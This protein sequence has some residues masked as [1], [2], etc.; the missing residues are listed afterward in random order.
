MFWSSLLAEPRVIQEVRQG[1]CRKIQSKDK[2]K[3]RVS[4]DKRQKSVMA[5][6]V[7]RGVKNRHRS[8]GLGVVQN[9]KS[10]FSG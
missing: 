4:R 6:S 7:S 8:G 5:A 9:P 1:V 2:I 3:K 10:Q